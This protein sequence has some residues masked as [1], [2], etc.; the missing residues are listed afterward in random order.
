M[1]TRTRYFVVVSLLVLGVGLGSGLV[2][3]YVGFPA[4]AASQRGG[5]EE[6][7]FIPRDAAVIGF[8]NVHDI[9]TSELRQKL[10]HA[11]PSQP[12]GQREFQEQTGINL[13]TDVDR[14]VACGRPDAGGMHTGGAGMILARGRF[15]E[16]KIEALMR[17]HGAQVEDYSGKRLIVA[18]VSR[19]FDIDVQPDA[20]PA[21]RNNGSF[22]VSFLEPGLAAVGSTSIVKTAVDLHRGGNNP[23][24]GLESVTGNDELMNLVRSMDSTSQNVWAVGRF[25]ALRANS[26]LPENVM[27]QIPAI[28]W[29]AVSGH[30]NGGIRGTIRAEA[31][32]DEAANNLRDVVRGF[33]ALAKL[34][35]G[36]NAGVQA[37][38]ESLELGGT[39]KTVSLSFAVPA[40]IFDIVGAAARGKLPRPQAH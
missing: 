39:G 29:F 32:D 27:S 13:E 5:P 18:D 21:P 28:S 31:R 2:A 20:A 11:L 12:E 25:D 35:A 16:V 8:A 10:H 24:A 38:V 15:D 14:I 17:E 1:T 22:A 23:Q 40:E 36:S 9:M 30:V 3:Y 7:Q 34:S 26:H 6:L 4:R 19:H 37:M 33:L